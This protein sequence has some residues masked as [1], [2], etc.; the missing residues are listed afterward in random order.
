MEY[1]LR[2]LGAEKHPGYS[3]QIDGWRIDYTDWKIKLD[4]ILG[5]RIKLGW[6]AS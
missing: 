2:L 4:G 6:L 1:K 5:P 3:V